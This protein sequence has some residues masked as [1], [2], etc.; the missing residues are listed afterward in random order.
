MSKE[1]LIIGDSNVKRFYSRL[2][3]QAQNLDVVAARNYTE[4]AQAVQ[5]SLKNSFKFIVLAC[6]TNLIIAAGD[7]GSCPKERLEA[8]EE[9]FNNLMPLLR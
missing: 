3:L 8:I 6:I 9:L 4:V 2:G 7:S 1:I 5:T